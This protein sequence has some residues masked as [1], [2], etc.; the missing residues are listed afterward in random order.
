MAILILYGGYTLNIP[1]TD[2]H[3]S[4]LVI[5]ILLDYQW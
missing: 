3:A 4:G 5:L 1:G 2:I